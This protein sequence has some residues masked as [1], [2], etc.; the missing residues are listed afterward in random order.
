LQDILQNGHLHAFAAPSLGPPATAPDARARESAGAFAILAIVSRTRHL[1]ACLLALTVLA[2]LL[3]GTAAAS[4]GGG[5]GSAGDQQYVDPLAHCHHGSGTSSS[6]ATTPAATTPATTP[7]ATPAAAT[8]STSVS[9]TPTA[10]TASD[11]KSAKAGKSLPYT[12][13]DLRYA[14]GLGVG[15]ILTGLG[16]RRLRHNY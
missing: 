3:P 6:S 15:L 1:L 9:T 8:T 7:S 10:T 2:V 5:G 16:L 4:C 11:P 13:F 12:G 14:L